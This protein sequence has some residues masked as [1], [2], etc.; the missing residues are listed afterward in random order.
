MKHFL[1][2]MKINKHSYNNYLTF[3]EYKKE[4]DMNPFSHFLRYRKNQI[5]VISVFGNILHIPSKPLKK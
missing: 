3:G 1:S 5:G 2:S 4:P